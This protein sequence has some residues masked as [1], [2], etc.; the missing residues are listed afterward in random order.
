MHIFNLVIL[1]KRA[2][3]NI[4][5]QE[6]CCNGCLDSACNSACRCRRAALKP[7]AMSIFD[8]SLLPCQSSMLIPLLSISHCRAHLHSDLLRTK[9]ATGDGHVLSLWVVF[10]NNSQAYPYWSASIVERPG[11]ATLLEIQIGPWRANECQM[12]AR[13]FNPGCK[14]HWLRRV[15]N[16]VS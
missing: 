13:K 16:H 7:T 1:L 2:D 11:L 3:H 15:C 6:R 12:V 4:Q 5:I 9:T 14:I 8:G 10:A